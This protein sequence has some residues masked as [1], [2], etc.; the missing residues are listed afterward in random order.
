MSTDPLTMLRRMDRQRAH[1]WP[2]DPDVLGVVPAVVSAAYP[3]RVVRTNGH[4]AAAALGAARRAHSSAAHLGL[5]SLHTDGF[6]LG[7]L[8][9]ARVYMTVSST[10][11]RHHPGCALAR[12]SATGPLHQQPLP[13]RLADVDGR[14]CTR[15]RGDALILDAGQWAYLWELACQRELLGEVGDAIGRAGSGLRPGD[16][17]DDGITAAGVARAVGALLLLTDRL[18]GL[19][20]VLAGWVGAHADAGIAALLGAPDWL[21]AGTGY[22]PDASR[23]R[24][25]GT[26]LR[27]LA[28]ARLLGVPSTDL[29]ALAAAERARRDDR[30]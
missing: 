27:A 28:G 7:P 24:D 14:R 1:D 25:A 2:T 17:R 20:S 21:T 3:T 13:D 10:G 4:L 15:C 30:R 18:P 26:A 8:A 16:P 9:G 19:P 23:Y 29:P 6:P 22:Q 12:R 11:M 5:G